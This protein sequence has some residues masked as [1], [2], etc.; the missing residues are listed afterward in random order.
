MT[1][2][3]PS[4]PGRAGL[5]RRA[6]SA[7]L[8]GLAALLVGIGLARFA[9]APLLPAVIAAGWFTAGEAAYL[10]AANLAGYVVGAL[11]A[12]R[13]AG[14]R[15]ASAGRVRAVLRWTM[16]VAALTFPASAWPAPFAWVFAWRVVSGIAGGVLMVLAAPVVLAAVP[17]ARRG[18]AGGLVFTGVGLGIAA[19]GTLVPVLLAHGLALAWLG[20]GL[21]A[22]ALALATWRAWPAEAPAEA[23]GVSPGEAPPPRPAGRFPVAWSGA[24]AALLAGYALNAAGL[25]PHMVFLVDFVARG[26]GHGIVAGSAHWVLFGLGA[27]AG[28]VLLGA[29]ADRIGFRSALSLAFAVQAIAVA[30]PAL[31]HGAVPLA[32]SSLVVGAFVPGIVPLVLGRVGELTRGEPAA[33][34]AAWGLATTAFALGQASAA[35]ALSWLYAATGAYP[36][37][38]LAGAGLLVLAL[39]LDLVPRRPR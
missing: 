14:G 17:A 33:R 32:L 27:A 16:V 7:T 13:L 10:G 8:A 25:V 24:L 6:W 37:L 26:L 31:D 36:P 29:L 3:A 21:L 28:P 22:L 23:P 4:R 39:V 12:R 20:L 30:A 1:S 15:E 18:F 35:F 38:F 19:S 2:G 34:Q 5:D 9:Y 11:G